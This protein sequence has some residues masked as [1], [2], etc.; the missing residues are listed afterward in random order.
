MFRKILIANRGEIAVRIIRTCKRLN[1]KT[2]AVYSEPDLGSLHVTMA[3]EAYPIGPGEPVESYLNIS[4]IVRVAQKSKAEAVHP[5]YGFLAENADFAKA[6]EEAH[7]SFVGPSSRILGRIANKL[8]S[9]KEALDAGIQ[10]IPGS[11][12]QTTTGEEAE[13]E[14][15][16]IGFPVLLKAAYGGGGRGMRVVKNPREM[17]KTFE[18]ASSEARTAFGHPELYV[19]K[20]LND[21]RHIEVQVIA[22]RRGRI[23]HLGERECSL[24]RR[25]QKILEETPSPA[26]TPKTR[27]ELAKK[28]VK[29]AKASKY[30]NA[31]TFEF[32]RSRTGEFY[33]LETNKRIQVE[34]LITE[35]V[36]GVDIV[37][38]Q[39]RIASGDSFDLSQNEIA[40]TGTAMNCRINAEDPENQFI[41]SPGH[42]AKFI[43]P[44]G[45]GVRVDTGLYD[46][47]VVP[48]YY[49]SLVA[50]IATQGRSRIE[51]IDRMKIA[52]AE[53]VIDGVK[54][55]LPLQQNLIE[56]PEFVKG[57]FGTQWL[58]KFQARLHYKSPPSEDEAALI[59]L[60]LTARK[61]DTVKPTERQ[62]FGNKWR[63]TPPAESLRPALF[64]EV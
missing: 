31:G 33:Y 57:H 29:L 18:I 20:Y 21:P 12:N 44:A 39:L 60:A 62:G 26:L 27:E 47:A 16:K 43:P 61:F 54:T 38:E 40:F 41:P 2:V 28:A 51:A 64:V 1:I 17:K 6:L 53:T 13:E 37:E 52:L 9:K 19:E 14:A 49:D 55:T 23:V 36:T 56:A 50:K 24:Q 46:G 35:M 7:M 15:E 8:E 59:F 10:P 30:E 3:N 11:K 25:H 5:G 34:H 22:G 32:V 63:V 42:I 45:P 48:Q 58:D 4:R